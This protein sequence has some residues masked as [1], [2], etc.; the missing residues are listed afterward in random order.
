MK[1]L[2][3]YAAVIFA[4]ILAASIIGGCLTAGV[5]VVKLIADKTG[6]FAEN[7]G[8]GIWYRDED[9]DVV[10]LGIRFGGSEDV[11]SGSES[12]AASE[13]DSMHLE[14]IT[15]ELILE[16]WEKEEISIMYEN[17]SEEYEIYNDGGTLVIERDDNFVFWEDSFTKTPKIHVSV[18]MDKVFD[19]VEVDKG[20]GSAKIIGITVDDLNIDNGSGGIGISEIKAERLHGEIQ[21]SHDIFQH[22]ENVV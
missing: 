10:F 7:N 11:M 20:S 15:G 13:I 1:Q 6:N 14:G 18:P 12:F 22:L 2:I 4:L 9:G 19:E 21:K 5:A 17:I 8:D 3:K 16:V